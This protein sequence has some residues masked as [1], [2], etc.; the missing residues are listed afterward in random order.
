ME[1]GINNEEDRKKEKTAK[2]KDESVIHRNI[3][4][5][6]HE[7]NWYAFDK[8]IE[9][10]SDGTSPVEMEEV[11]LIKMMTGRKKM[12]K[13]SQTKQQILEASKL[14]KVRE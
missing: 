9:K 11:K 4:D 10:F 1:E 14:V 5:N 6:E 12:R 13:N 3:T 8:V 7:T 2:N